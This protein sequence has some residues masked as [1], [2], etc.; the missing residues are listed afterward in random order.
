ME[1]T[2]QIKKEQFEEL[3]LAFLYGFKTGG[4]KQYFDLWRELIEENYSD[5]STRAL[6]RIESFLEDYAK[7]LPQTDAWG[8]FEALIFH[9]IDYREDFLKDTKPH[10][11][12][13]KL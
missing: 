1:T 2:V 6:C 10:F 4:G 5:L 7:A 3:V 13:E 12:P 8:D 9:E 11:V